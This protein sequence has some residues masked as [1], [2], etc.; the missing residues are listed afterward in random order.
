MKDTGL[1]YAFILDGTGGGRQ[2]GWDEIRQW[3]K[4]QGTLWVHLDYSVEQVRRW[5]ETESGL[6]EVSAELLLTEE[7]RPRTTIIDNGVLIALRGVNLSPDSDP[8][9][10]VSIRIRSDQ[11]RIITTRKRA[12]LSAS[13]LAKSILNGRGP[14]TTAEFIVDL[15]DRMINRMEG[16]IENIEDS[17]AHVEEEIVVSSRLELRQ[18]LSSIRRQV[19]MLRRYLAPQREALSK[20][21]TEKI[22]WFSETDRIRIHEVSDK[23]IRFIEDLDSLRDRAAVTQE[24]LVNRISEQMNVRMYVLS[25]VAAI[26]LPLGFLTGLLGINVGGIPGA[27]NKWAFLIFILILA[28]VVAFQFYLFKKKKWI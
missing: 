26:F 10:M 14:T 1:I 27:E 22:P 13:D 21:F 12:L 19:I 20:L 16:T 28:V 17:V 23:L 7:T 9:D 18:Q 3:E 4:N 24:E 8:E 5:V 6:D 15:G 2:I 25:L 11:H